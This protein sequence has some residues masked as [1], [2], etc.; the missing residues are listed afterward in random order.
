LK[1]SVLRKQ[2]W[3]EESCTTLELNKHGPTLKPRG[4]IAENSMFPSKKQRG[5]N[6]PAAA[7]KL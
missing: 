3:W 5:G 4:H 6:T 7:V 2:K 1:I